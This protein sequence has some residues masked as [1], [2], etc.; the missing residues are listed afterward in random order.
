MHFSSQNCGENIWE[1]IF[2]ARDT[3]NC[4]GQWVKLKLTSL[5]L[6]PAFCWNVGKED[7]TKTHW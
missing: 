7:I 2:P 1:N 4:E 5:V 3:S 6:C